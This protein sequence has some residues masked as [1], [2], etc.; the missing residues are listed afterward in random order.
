MKALLKLPIIT[1]KQ[2]VLYLLFQILKALRPF[3]MEMFIIAYTL[4]VALKTL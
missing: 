4:F 1:D 2:S 3:K